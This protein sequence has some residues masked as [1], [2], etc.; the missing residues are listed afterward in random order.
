MLCF[1]HKAYICPVN[2]LS[3]YYFDHQEGNPYFN[4]GL[5]FPDI[6]R[7]FVRGSKLNFTIDMKDTP[8]ADSLQKGCIQHVQSDKIFH[9]W[10]GF[11]EAM[12]FATDFMRNSPLNFQKDWFIAHILV[13]VTMD[14]YLILNSPNLASKLYTDFEI[15]DTE[16]IH[17][18]L[19]RNDFSKFDLFQKGFDRFMKV[20][21]LESYTE[22]NNI[23]YA[24][25]RI[26][27]KM[28]LPPFSEEQKQLL[29]SIITELNDKMPPMVEDLKVELK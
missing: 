10:D 3:H 1:I 5:I 18:F 11:I 21:Y 17:S 24:L 9:A 28:R 14:H 4:L 15:V 19:R 7:N 27:T 2:F 12:D 8:S 22:P 6:V 26:C 29:K 23:V 20:R 25:G 16:H 13:E